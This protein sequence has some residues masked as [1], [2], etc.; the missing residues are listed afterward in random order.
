MGYSVKL[1]TKTIDYLPRP[2]R[3]GLA[4]VGINI[5]LFE[6]TFC[7]CKLIN[8]IF[9]WFEPYEKMSGNG[10]LIRCVCL[11][12][13]FFIGIGKANHTFVKMLDFTLPLWQMIII[14]SLTNL[15]WLS[16]VHK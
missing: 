15:F 13:F 5:V 12:S 11:A 16:T 2:I 4:L 1:I 9:E 6:V 10:K 7:V 3:E 14:G 8:H